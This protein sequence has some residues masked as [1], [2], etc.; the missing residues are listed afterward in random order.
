MDFIIKVL[1]PF[2]CPQIAISTAP[3]KSWAIKGL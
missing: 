2:K 3:L 1:F